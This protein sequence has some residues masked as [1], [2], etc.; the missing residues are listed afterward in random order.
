[1]EFL[2][3]Q[4]DEILAGLEP[5]PAPSGNRVIEDLRLLSQ[6]AEFAMALAGCR[7]LAGTGDPQCAPA[8]EAMLNYTA[9]K[10]PIAAHALGRGGLADYVM[11]LLMS[12]IRFAAGQ[13]VEGLA[14][15]RAMSARL[16]R[17]I[18]DVAP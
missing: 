10:A 8:L 1:M 3:R 12:Q 16:E 13:P 6:D 17:I 2:E 9:A 18:G 5:L 11:S 7:I 4:I 15:L 14:V